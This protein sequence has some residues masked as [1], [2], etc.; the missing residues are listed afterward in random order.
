MLAGVWGVQQKE[1]EEELV[2]VVVIE[3]GN[4]CLPLLADTFLQKIRDITK[5][6]AAEKSYDTTIVLRHV[7]TTILHVVANQDLDW[8]LRLSANGNICSP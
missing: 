2:A 8:P 6:R 5:C 3:Q 7:T 1:D 4:W